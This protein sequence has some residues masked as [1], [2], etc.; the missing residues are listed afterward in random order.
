MQHIHVDHALVTQAFQHLTLVTNDR[1]PE[2]PHLAL[3]RYG[4]QFIRGEIGIILQ[5][6]AG[7]N[8]GIMEAYSAAGEMWLSRSRHNWSLGARKTKLDD[9]FFLIFY[10]LV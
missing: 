10:L 5:K 1:Q 8:A 3:Q 6:S 9:M 2:R 4:L 7:L